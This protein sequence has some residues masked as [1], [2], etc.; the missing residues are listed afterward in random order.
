M[1]I[2]TAITKVSAQGEQITVDVCQWNPVT[3]AIVHKDVGEMAQ[4]MDT[5]L[6]FCDVRLEEMNLRMLEAYNLEEYFTPGEWQK[7]LSILGILGGQQSA[8]MVR[9]RWDAIREEN[10]AL[11]KERLQHYNEEMAQAIHEDEQISL[12]YGEKV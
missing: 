10:H 8:A 5:M 2:R 3:G 9:Q 6:K 1:P 4:L 7:V 11:E 12:N